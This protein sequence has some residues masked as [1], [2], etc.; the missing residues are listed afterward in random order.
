VPAFLT[1]LAPPSPQRVS[2]PTVEAPVLRVGKKA[3]ACHSAALCSRCRYP[4]AP[5]VPPKQPSLPPQTASPSP[6]VKGEPVPVPTELPF[7]PPLVPPAPKLVR[8]SLLLDLD[9][10]DDGDDDGDD[11][12]CLGASAPSAGAASAS[13]L[14]LAHCGRAVGTASGQ[15]LRAWRAPKASRPTNAQVRTGDCTVTRRV[16]VHEHAAPS[17]HVGRTHPESSSSHRGAVSAQASAVSACPREAHGTISA[18]LSLPF[19]SP[20]WSSGSP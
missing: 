5:S 11:D 4:E 13:H 18:S 9:D 15:C 8:V 20:A 17:T 19:I 12:D 7:R 1:Q 2:P 10:D 14:R 6:K 3:F 16:R